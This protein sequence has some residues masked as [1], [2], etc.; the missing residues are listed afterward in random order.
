MNGPVEGLGG[1]LLHQLVPYVAV[2]AL[3][4]VGVGSG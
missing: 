2:F 1:S 3:R 4:R